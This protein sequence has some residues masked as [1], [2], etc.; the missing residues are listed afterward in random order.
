MAMQS[1]PV[2]N[3]FVHFDDLEDVFEQDTS[4][5]STRRRTKRVATAPAQALTFEETEEL[6][7]RST[8][9]ESSSCMDEDDSSDESVSSFLCRPCGIDDVDI[10]TST[11][12]ASQCVGRFHLDG[13]APLDAGSYEKYAAAQQSMKETNGAPVREIY[14]NIPIS[15]PMDLAIDGFADRLQVSFETLAQSKFNEVGESVVSLR[16]RLSDGPGGP[17]PLR[18]AQALPTTVDTPAPE[19]RK[20]TAVCCH[21]KQKGFCAYQSTCKF[22]HPEHKRGVGAGSRKNRSRCASQR[23]V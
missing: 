2:K 7:D 4:C 20:A 8:S 14:I 13:A 19:K 5:C 12:T 6:S 18:L 10:L 1:A 22:L 3:T 15:L 23:D 16:V 9:L 11:P 21:W 17:V